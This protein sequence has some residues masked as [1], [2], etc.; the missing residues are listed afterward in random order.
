MVCGIHW[1]KLVCLFASIKSVRRDGSGH[2]VPLLGGAFF[3]SLTCF[4]Y[5]SIIR[6][7]IHQKMTMTKLTWLSLATAGW[8]AHASM[9]AYYE[10]VTAGQGFS[11]GLLETTGRVEC[12]GE[13]VLGDTPSLDV[14]EGKLLDEDHMSISGGGFHVCGLYYEGGEKL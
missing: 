4:R 9:D 11:C 14:L 2:V 10:S 7:S 12:W 1:F 13:G 5:A 6:R 3:C 8:L